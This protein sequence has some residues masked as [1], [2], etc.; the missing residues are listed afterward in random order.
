MELATGPLPSRAPR[1][2]PTTERRAED[3]W[4]EFLQRVLLSII[5]AK[6][7]DFAGLAPVSALPAPPVSA[8]ECRAEVPAAQLP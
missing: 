1:T 5:S 8:S 7:T 4:G 2:A 6:D 3:P